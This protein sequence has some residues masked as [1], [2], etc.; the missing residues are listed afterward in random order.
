MREAHTPS[1]L[2][3]DVFMRTQRSADIV[4]GLFLTALGLVVGI[5]AWGLKSSFGEVLP[6]SALPLVLAGATMVAGLGLSIKAYGYRG[7]PVPVDWPARDGWFR[8]AV[9]F[10]SL[11][12]YLA[13]IESLGAALASFLF[14]AF[15]VWYLDG[16]ILPALYVGAGTALVIE[17][18]FIKGLMM[19]FPAAFWAR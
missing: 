13:L 18:A 4:A 15:L 14:A 19:P 11:V 9:T 1:F 7:E 3:R 17:Y 6:P 12:C 5:A 2:T 16:R 10:L 8:L